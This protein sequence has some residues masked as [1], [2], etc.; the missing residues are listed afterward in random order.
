MLLIQDIAPYDHTLVIQCSR[1]S[2]RHLHPVSDHL[3]YMQCYKRSKHWRRRRPGTKLD[4]CTKHY[5]YVK[6][7]TGPSSSNV[8]MCDYLHGVGVNN[9]CIPDNVVRYILMS[10]HR[11][12]LY[13]MIL[14]C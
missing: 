1:P 5:Y 10:Q 13:Y 14:N 11:I 7:C 6:N 9:T 12:I 4:K 2:S 3:Q 8:K